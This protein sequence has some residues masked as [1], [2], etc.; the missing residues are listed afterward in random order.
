MVRIDHVADT[1]RHVDAEHQRID[2]LPAGG[3]AVFGERKA[4]EATGPAGWMIVLRCVSS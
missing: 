2:E 4:A 1:A 3:A